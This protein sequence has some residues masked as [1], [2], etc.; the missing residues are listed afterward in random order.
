[1][2]R[3]SLLISLVLLVAA[4][5]YTAVVIYRAIFVFDGH[6]FVFWGAIALLTAIM[7]GLVRL[8]VAVIVR[9]RESFASRFARPS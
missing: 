6:G 5:V 7:V 8:T 4:A 2:R 1:M 3:P 9:L